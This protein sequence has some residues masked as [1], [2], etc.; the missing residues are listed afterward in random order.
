MSIIN[1]DISI[2]LCGDVLITKRL[3]EQL[4]ESALELAE[5]VKSH[6]VKFANLETTIRKDEGYPAVFPGGGFAMTSPN[7]IKDLSKS[8]GFNVYN[9][10]NNHSMDYSEG[11]LLSTIR[12]L[13]DIDVLHC[14]T[15]R[16]LA[17]A[18]KAVFKECKN[19][20][21]AF[22]GVTSSF[23][24]AYSAGPQN[25]ELQGRPGVAPLRHK[26]IYEVT[27]QNYSAL[28]RIANDIGINNGQNQSIKEGYVL[29]SEYLKFGSFEFERGG[30]NEVHTTPLIEDVQRTEKI[31]QDAKLQADVV[32]VSIHSH[33]FKGIDKAIPTDFCRIFSQKCIEAGADV[34]VCHGPHT[35]RGVEVYKHGVILHGLGDFIFEHESMAVLPEE[36]Y[37]RFGTTRHECTG[38]A[39]LMEK[40]SH[41]GKVGLIA[42]D[43]AWETVLVSM[44]C[45]SEN[46]T[47]KFYPVHIERGYKGGLPVLASDT[48]I[49]SR[50]NNLSE[51]YGCMIGIDDSKVVGL[52]NI[53]RK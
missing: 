42:D 12:Y 10:A 16:N 41:G 39:G 21:V 26:A 3:P 27:D 52:L 23:N 47:L 49:L 14:G 53:N 50:L 6:E 25:E 13:E 43:K 1:H 22:L 36:Y 11:A 48:S 15:G 37:Q 7:S 4:N 24:A 33:Q 32:V 46:L 40:R 30:D 9:T 31:I 17:E 38:V 5:I 51:E 8:Y 19:G 45:T 18:T 2:S 20:R 34:V 29:A 28:K 35:L 44:L